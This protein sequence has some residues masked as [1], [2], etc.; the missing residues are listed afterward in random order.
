PRYKTAALAQSLARCI[1][2]EVHDL[3]IQDAIQPG[4]ADDAVGEDQ[5]QRVQ[6]DA[7]EPMAEAAKG[8]VG[9][10][11][12]GFIHFIN[13]KLVAQ[14]SEDGG[15]GRFEDVV[16]FSGVRLQHTIN[17]STDTDAGKNHQCR[18]QHEY[19]HSAP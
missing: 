17:Q 18:Y 14:D 3:F 4:K 10:N 15:I 13:I 8:G 12:R 11:D 9:A 2:T 1:E 6:H 16:R 19:Q 7:V 5:H